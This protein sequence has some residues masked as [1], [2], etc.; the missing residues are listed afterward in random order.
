M[1]RE[2]SRTAMAGEPSKAGVHIR[3]R[4]ER[5]VC[6]GF[7]ARGRPTYPGGID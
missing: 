1:T 6:D 5:G 4:Y 2:A 7:E 3:P